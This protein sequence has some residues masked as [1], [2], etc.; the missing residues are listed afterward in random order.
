MSECISSC[1]CSCPVVMAAMVESLRWAVVSAVVSGCSAFLCFCG[2]CAKE[3]WLIK[4]SMVA[5]NSTLMSFFIS[6]KF[7]GERCRL[8][9]CQFL[10]FCNTACVMTTSKSS[11]KPGT[12]FC[13]FRS[14]RLRCIVMPIMQA[15]CPVSSMW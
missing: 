13:R 11:F 7:I 5:A 12:G 2:S 14:F 1:S 4:S 10:S 15:I 3:D 8:N 9:L 6:Q